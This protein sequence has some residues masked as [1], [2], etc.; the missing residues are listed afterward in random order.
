MEVT[1]GHSRDKSILK[2][3]TEMSSSHLVRKLCLT[4][5]LEVVKRAWWKSQLWKQTELQTYSFSH[6]GIHYQGPAFLKGFRCACWI[7]GWHQSYADISRAFK[8]QAKNQTKELKAYTEQTH[9]TVLLVAF[10]QI[11]IDSKGWGTGPWVATACKMSK[12]QQK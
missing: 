12:F 6:T 3:L 10:K 8:S 2:T 4:T 11:N 5:G 9:G 1:G 7:A